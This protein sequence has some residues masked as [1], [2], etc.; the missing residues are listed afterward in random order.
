[1]L[2]VNYVHFKVKNKLIDKHNPN[3]E[4]FITYVP[5]A[6]PLQAWSDPEGSRNLRLP[7]FKTT[8]PNVVR[9]SALRTAAFTPRKYSWYSFLL[10]A[11]STPE[12]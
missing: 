12:P 3:F 4:T 7:D 2:D 10:E 1:M 5:K 8:A 11:E 6:V 9:L